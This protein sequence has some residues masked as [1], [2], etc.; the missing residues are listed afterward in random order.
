MT[1]L[2]GMGE[3][4]DSPVCCDDKESRATVEN[5]SRRVDWAR[6]DPDICETFSCIGITH[7]LGD[8]ELMDS[9]DDMALSFAR[10]KL[11]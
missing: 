9:L 7:A 2:E 3:D 5:T 1:F 11:L 10:N 4:E 6:N 8:D